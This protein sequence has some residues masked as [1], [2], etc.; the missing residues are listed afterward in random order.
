MK[1]N[2]GYNAILNVI[3]QTLS[4]IFPLISYPYVLRVLGVENI[5]K[6][7]Y[8]SSIIGYFTLFAMLGFSTY[9][10]REG[11][12]IRDD[13]GKLSMFC[14]EIFSLNVLSTLLSFGTLLIFLIF[15][16]NLHAYTILLLITSVSIFATT[17][18]VDWI[19]I[20][21]E[22]YLY[23]TI[24][25]IVIY[26]ISLGM[27]F[28]FV[29]TSSDYLVYAA[30]SSCT[31]LIIC[32]SNMVHI[33][34]YVH[35][36]LV[37]RNDWKKHIVPVLIFFANSL[38]ITIYVNID[39]TML[40][41]VKGDYC[42]GIYSTGVKIYSILKNILAAIYVVFVPRLAQYAKNNI[43]E[44]KKTLTNLIC[45]V[46]MMLVP[47]SVGLFCL[48]KEAILLIAGPS[49][50]EAFRVLQ[51]LS[52]ALIFA[53]YGGIFTAC[54]NVTLNREKYTLVATI[55]GASINFMLNLYAIPQFGYLGAATTTLIS[56]MFVALF[57]MF[58]MKNKSK[59]F[60]MKHILTTIEETILESVLIVIMYNILS[61]FLDNYIYRIVT[62]VL[63]SIVSY[64]VIL[65][66]LKNPYFVQMTK[67]FIN[68][69]K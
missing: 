13:A 66:V 48:S 64:I 28:L 43:N 42:V 26:I 35:L 20:I 22:D 52:I 30:I 17:F 7:N 53:I 68:N 46:S 32:I 25:S 56:E 58:V 41:W 11:A 54:I 37:I 14:N 67:K 59:Y 33:R 50:G 65:K 27:L 49:Y 15:V 31:N 45:I 40:G 51:I 12:K 23:I 2:I 36:R 1:R 9:A 47:A 62:L 55:L 18:S 10:V 8:A 69:Y 19:N 3:R 24:R 44:Y 29:K 6:V 21:F 34:R 63:A 57:S 5:G 60:E 4:I 61:R 39:T 38:A 16:K